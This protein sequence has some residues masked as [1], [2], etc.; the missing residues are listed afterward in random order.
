M[1]KITHR[2]FLK[3]VGAI[4]AVAVM[5]ACGSSAASSSAA[6]KTS[7][8]AGSTSASTSSKAAKGGGNLVVYSPNADNELD[9]ILT[10]FGKKYG[11]TIDVQSMGSGDCYAKLDS[12]KSNP[13]ADVMFGGINLG[14]WMQ[15]PDL[16]EKYVAAG[17]DKL[18]KAFQNPNGYITMYLSN[19][20]CLLVN[21]DQEKKLGLDIQGYGDLLNP[22]LKGLIGSADPTAS[23]SAYAQLTNILLAEGGYEN[24][25]A[26][27]YVGDLIGQLNGKLTSGSSAVYKGV[28][29]GEYA[30][31]LTYELPCIDL[32][33]SGA[34]NIRV[35]YPKEGA[36][37]LA[38][39]SAIVKNAKNMDN[40]KLFMDFLVSDECQK[41]VAEKTYARP[42]S[43]VDN[44]SKYMKSLKD[45]KMLDEDTEYTFTNK[46]KI[47]AH[48]SELWTK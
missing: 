21:T 26:W 41:I 8:T 7:S 25:A 32:L 4:A 40:A 19:G 23:S 44:A 6:P 31:G 43:G 13:Q 34:T 20:S 5:T 47:Q 2:S 37:W 11:I 17:N 30:V 3:A 39:G 29:N 12:E 16:F 28:Y 15:Y 33:E 46:T 24:D 18:P 14:Y 35:V 36:V 22:K 9:N 48:W 10:Y 38:S 27:K 42:V 1:K 45:I